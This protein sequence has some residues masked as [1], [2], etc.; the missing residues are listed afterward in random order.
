M[1]TVKVRYSVEERL[2]Y[3]GVMDMDEEKFYEMEALS[4]TDLTEAILDRIERRDPSNWI[5]EDCAQFEI[6]EE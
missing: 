4:D 5:A 3:S 1:A 2:F 6:V